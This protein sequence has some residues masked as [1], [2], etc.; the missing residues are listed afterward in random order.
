MVP[1]PDST[2][3]INLPRNIYTLNLRQCDVFIV[4]EGS[5]ELLEEIKRSVG[6]NDMTHS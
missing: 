5:A 6:L 3:L 2:D 4:E 1:V